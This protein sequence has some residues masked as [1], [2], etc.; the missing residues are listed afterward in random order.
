MLLGHAG[1]QGTSTEEVGGA[2]RDEHIIFSALWCIVLTALPVAFAGSV[3]LCI[4]R[5]L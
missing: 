4:A 1:E 5:E 2:P 3:P